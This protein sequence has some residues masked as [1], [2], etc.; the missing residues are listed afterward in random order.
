MGRITEYLL[1]QQEPVA[2]ALSRMQ[3]DDA[4]FAEAVKIWL[5]LLARF[6][7]GFKKQHQVVVE[8]SKDCLEDGVFLAANL[9]HQMFGGSRLNETQRCATR[10]Q[11]ETA[12]GDPTSFTRILSRDPPFRNSDF[13]LNVP[14]ST[15]WRA[16]LRS[17]CPARLPDLG[18]RFASAVPTS[19]GLERQ[20]SRL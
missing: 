5:D 1:L 12:C 17:G 4:T 11:V 7:A 15:W 14:S 13:D 8:R 20:F 2:E 6:P 18:L 19:A 16:G 9:L 3:S 10:T